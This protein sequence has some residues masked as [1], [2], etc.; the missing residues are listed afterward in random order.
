MLLNTKELIKSLKV[1]A[2]YAEKKDLSMITAYVFFMQENGKTILKATDNEV[3]ISID[4]G[5]VENAFSF[6]VRLVELLE[7]AI[8][9]NN[10]SIEF[11]KVDD[12]IS[13]K[14]GLS[15][16]MLESFGI[17]EMYLESLMLED[18]QR[19]SVAKVI[20]NEINISESIFKSIDKN[21]PKFELNGMLL[22]LKNK[23]LIATDTRRM[24]IQDIDIDCNGLE[25]EIIIPRAAVQDVKSITDITISKNYI[26]F[27]D[28]DRKI[29]SRQIMG[30]YPDYERIISHDYNFKVKINGI[31]LKNYLK[32][33]KKCDITLS[34]KNNIVDIMTEA[35]NKIQLECSY[36]SDTIFE[37]SCDK[38]YLQDAIIDNKIELCFNDSEM[39]FTVSQEKTKTVIMP[40]VFNGSNNDIKS[41]KKDFIE[42]NSYFT[43]KEATKK[44]S[45]AVNKDKIIRDL[46]KKVLELEER[47]KVY[48]DKNSIVKNK[49]FNNIFENAKKVMV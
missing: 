43:Y 23:K 17:T 21:N 10:E 20:N 1:A 25:D 29:T 41:I 12:M 9:C 37:I 24:A 47:L 22:D 42:K 8:A 35:G 39:P 30:K 7:F 5:V 18:L 33:I 14:S 27:K 40:I 28:G 48:E 11:Y 31:E 46:E 13:V 34:F 32:K 38:M 6:D 15:T 16:T 2:K 3:G 44:R 49:I 26:S 45:P 4:L 36:P 19:S